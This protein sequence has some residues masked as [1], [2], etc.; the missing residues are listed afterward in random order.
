MSGL[1]GA[2][3]AAY[4]A[5]STWLGSLLAGKQQTIRDFFLGGRRLP[6]LAVC[7]SIVAS[8]ISGVTFVS[9]PA[10]SWSPGGNF[11]YLQLWIGYFLARA[12]IGYVFVPAFY[13]REIYSPYQFMGERL[14]PAADRAATG[15]FF[16]GGF[17]AQGARL[18]LA[19]LVLDAI[20]GMGLVGAIFLMGAVSVV[21]TW[22]GGISTVIWTDV[23]QFAVLFLGAAA[24]LAAVLLQVPGGVDEAVRA[25]AAADKFRVFDLRTDPTIPFTLWCGLIGA[26]FQNL[27]S[28]GTDQMM[29]QRLFCCRDERAARKAILGSCVAVLLAALMLA[30]GLGLHAYFLRKPLNPAE[31]ARVQDRI[32]YIFPIFIM[33][34]MPVGAKGLLFAAIFA[35]ATATSTL[36]AMA[37]TA[38][39]TFYKPALKKEA[40]ERHLL[41]ASR[42]LVLAAGVILCGAA[43]MCREIRRYPDV[44][45][46]ALA[47]ST[48]TYGPLLGIFLLALLPVRRDARGLL[49]GVPFSLLLLL[50]LDWQHLAWVRA[51]VLPAVILLCAAA[52]PVLRREWPRLFWVLAA[53]ALVLAAAYLDHRK[54]AWPWLLPIGT[55][56]TL[57]LGIVLG[58]KRLAAPGPPSV[59]CPAAS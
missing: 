18:Y 13:R 43:V 19:A 53:A 4:I 26:T 30:V 6:W 32:D 37:Q 57:G 16:L 29:A 51:V 14:G 48:Y 11:T 8:E 9:I 59:S 39:M 3:L 34:E 49:W 21:W 28:H 31:T 12:I 54:L 20:T 5:G 58:R 33:R 56:F 17:L 7:G 25:A 46:L 50:A 41:L 55:L 1:D 24:A 36:A 38:L 40:S 22:I 52:V 35:A 27:A 10:S 23:V 15:L 44:L 45:N 42:V 47:M 2:I